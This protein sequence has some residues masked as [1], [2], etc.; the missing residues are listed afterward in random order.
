MKH[1]TKGETFKLYVSPFEIIEY[2]SFRKVKHITECFTLISLFH[3]KKNTEGKNKN[4]M[5]PF[6]LHLCFE[7]NET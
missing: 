3:T 7:E 2:Q 5:G 6:A 4:T 1:E